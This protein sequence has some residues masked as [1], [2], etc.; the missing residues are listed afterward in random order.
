[1]GKSLEKSRFEDFEACFKIDGARLE[2]LLWN[3]TAFWESELEK[4]KQ[5]DEKV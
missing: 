2:K 3:E 4:K 1:M 5:T